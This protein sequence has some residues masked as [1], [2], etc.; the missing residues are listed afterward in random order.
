MG[1]YQEAKETVRNYFE[2]LENSTPENVQSVLEE[3]TGESYKWRGVYPFREQEGQKAV[4][5]LWLLH[6]AL[7]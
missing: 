1:R 7:L 4:A 5:D 3:F 2:A 6:S